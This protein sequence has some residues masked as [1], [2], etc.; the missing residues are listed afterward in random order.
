[1]TLSVQ[2]VAGQGAVRLVVA[3]DGPGMDPQVRARA[4]DPFYCGRDAGRR[5]GLGLPKAYQAV[6]AS[7]GQMMLESEPGQGTTVRMTFAVV[8]PKP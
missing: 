1:V 5:R 8:E 7:A 4:F 3:D 6:L 2:P